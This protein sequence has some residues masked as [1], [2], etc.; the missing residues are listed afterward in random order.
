[1]NAFKI[2]LSLNFLGIFFFAQ[3][4]EPKKACPSETNQKYVSEALN[5]I[6]SGFSSGKDSTCLKQENF[7]LFDLSLTDEPDTNKRSH[8][9]LGENFETSISKKEF[10]EM[11]NLRVTFTITDG[12]KSLGEDSFELYFHLDKECAAFFSLPKNTYLKK[13][14]I[15]D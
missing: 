7:K 13:N 6:T 11:G 15:K 1:M 12:N 5:L 3:A 2:L 9:L 10:T 14:C 4:A 8:F